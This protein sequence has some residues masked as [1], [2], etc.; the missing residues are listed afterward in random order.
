MSE[1]EEKNEAAEVVGN[2]HQL[3]GHKI[4]TVII[5]AFKQMAAERDGSSMML[6]QQQLAESCAIIREKI[7]AVDMVVLTDEDEKK[8]LH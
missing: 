6:L 4:E 3:Y 7:G 5:E 2:Y 8:G 1:N